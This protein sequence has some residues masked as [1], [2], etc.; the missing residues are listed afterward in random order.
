MT[1]FRELKQRNVVKVGAIYAVTAWL[2]IQVA[3]IGFPEFGAPPWAL[4]I[5][6]FVV[7]LGFPLAL[8]LAWAL[9][10]TPE[11]IKRAQ[12]SVGEKRMW[13]ITIGLGALAIAWFQFGQPAWRNAND[14][15]DPSIAVLPF[16][17]LSPQGDQQ[18]FG[19]GI[20]EEILNLL[21]QNPE[22]RVAGRT[23]SFKFR[24]EETDLREVGRQLSVAHVLEGSVR[25]AGQQLR[26][27][28]QLIDTETGYH[29]WSET[30]DRELT[31]VFAVQDQISA[32]IVDAL[33]ARIASNP[34]VRGK[35]PTSSEAAYELYLRARSMGSTREIA[36]VED[37]IRLLEAALVLDDS[38]A[39]AWGQLSY[40]YVI[41]EFWG[42]SLPT[43]V[44]LERGIEAANRS[45]ALDPD[46][47]DGLLGLGVTKMVR[48][49]EMDEARELLHRAYEL[50]PSNPDVV[51]FIGDYYGRIIDRD[52]HLELEHL[53]AELD[54][55]VPIHRLDLAWS[56]A[57]YGEPEKA[58]YWLEQAAALNDSL[59]IIAEPS[60]DVLVSVG[61]LE[62]ARQMAAR[63][64]EAY[65]E[66]S[67]QYFH[68]RASL[69]GATGRHAELR[70]YLDQVENSPLVDDIVETY[71]AAHHMAA[72]DCDG[73]AYWMERARDAHDPFLTYPHFLTGSAQCPDSEA[74]QAFWN[75]PR[76]KWLSDERLSRGY[77][78]ISFY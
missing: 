1:F 5:F 67:R 74:W 2:L 38:Y 21:A 3:S 57:L 39:D 34:G 65:G 48:T 26:I 55:L 6:I 13:A 29:L 64:R 52:R 72:G 53:A 30:Y 61:R 50:A 4:R 71:L 59:D 70:M 35:R 58:L 31:D 28:A 62:E 10:L 42:S 19:D 77:E 33:N 78:A 68:A 60:I 63:V 69:L 9:E 37:A 51:N 16:S 54:P 66:Q 20:A 8:I 23:S 15:V 36:Q 7:L 25:K 49:Y 41:G 12:G 45:L 40:L 22:L 44:A 73:A 11:G 75:D 76:F 24:G 46:N 56:Y 47:V 43:D 32:A 14:V 17:D 27:T 18:Y